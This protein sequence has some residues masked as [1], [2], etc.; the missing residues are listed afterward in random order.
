LHA[1]P[2]DTSLAEGSLTGERSTV[3]PS[4]LRRQDG[5]VRETIKYFAIFVVFLVMILD[6]VAV[7]QVQLSVR[8]NAKSA[9]Q[10]AQQQFVSGGSTK[11][12]QMAAKSYLDSKDARYISATVTP[13]VN[14][15]DPVVTVVAERSA[16]TYVYHYFEKLPW[17]LGKRVTN[18]LNP[19]A[20]ENS[21]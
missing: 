13:G 10:E 8:D 4:R 6:A 14:G 5:F 15:G 2:P 19:T 1:R 20:V 7:L 11:Q 16:H 18:L 12:A 17:G 9:A 3:Q 21:N